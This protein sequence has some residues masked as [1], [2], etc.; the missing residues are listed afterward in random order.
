MLP[1]SNE[2]TADHILD[3]L[4]HYDAF[5]I[6]IAHG[7]NV[8]ARVFAERAY[9]A[10]VVAEGDDSPGTTKSKLFTEGSTEYLSYGGFR[11]SRSLR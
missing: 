7:D 1:Q 8:R 6:A 2:K 4:A 10:S 5:Q 9:S 11:E 3:T